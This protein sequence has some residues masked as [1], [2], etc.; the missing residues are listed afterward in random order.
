MPSPAFPSP[1]SS[2]SPS[3]LPSLDVDLLRTLVTVVDCGSFSRAAERLRR[4]QSAVSLQIKR[5]EDRVGLRLIDRSPRHLMLTAEGERMLEDARHLLSLHDGLVARLLEPE[6]AGVVRFGAP[7]DFA[8]SHLPG[9]LARFSAL[10]PQVALEVTCELT[11][12]L[13]DRFQA[14]E[15]DLALIKREPGAPLAATND[16]GSG[17]RDGVPVWREALVWVGAPG[18]TQQEVLPLAVSP[19]PCVYRKR[20]TDALDGVGRSWRIS[21]TCGSLAG[22]HAAVRAGL[23]VTVLPRD[24]VPAGLEVLDADKQGLPHLAET[25]IALISAPGLSPAAERFRSEMIRAL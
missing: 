16:H 2:S 21:Y 19:R 23:G 7:E 4:G 8:T 12:H 6:V 24:M 14:G 13:L 17:P 11:L 15:L 18:P 9:V 5:L 3:S 25:E 10:Y 1:S 22:T 20:A